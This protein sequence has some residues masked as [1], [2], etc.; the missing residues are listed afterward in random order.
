M[1]DQQQDDGSQAIESIVQ[2]EMKRRQ[3]ETQGYQAMMKANQEGFQ[4]VNE[5]N[6]K[7]SEVREGAAAKRSA[8]DSVDFSKETQKDMQ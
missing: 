7:S 4:A 3:T 2:M 6:Q 1:A 8:K 5:S